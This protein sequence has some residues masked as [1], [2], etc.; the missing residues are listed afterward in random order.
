MKQIS[1]RQD[2]YMNMLLKHGRVSSVNH[3][4]QVFGQH[5]L[6]KSFGITNAHKYI[7]SIFPELKDIFKTKKAT[8]AAI[9]QA[10]DEQK[11]T[12]ST[13]KFHV[14][15]NAGYRTPS[16]SGSR[17][18]H[19]DKI[20]RES[21]E[22]WAVHQIDLWESNSEIF[23]IS[24]LDKK[25][26][27]LQQKDNLDQIHKLHHKYWQNSKKQGVE[28]ETLVI[29]LIEA[30]VYDASTKNEWLC[31]PDPGMCLVDTVTNE[32]GETFNIFVFESRDG[33]YDTFFKRPHNQVEHDFW[34]I[35]ESED[36]P[37]EFSEML[38]RIVAFNDKYL[39]HGFCFFDIQKSIVEGRFDGFPEVEGQ[40]EDNLE[41]ETIGPKM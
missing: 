3:Y 37:N 18:I 24:V 32:N 16:G 31:L 6:P 27:D 35:K 1:Q 36:Y 17:P 30:G 7:M 4:I 10:V 12:S 38:Q 11:I 15:Y 40:P 19:Y 25:V 41:T 5:P 9:K 39:P 2:E 23:E 14:N 29:K 13:S 26:S 28:P 21:L 34:E 8:V 33:E 20:D 22:A